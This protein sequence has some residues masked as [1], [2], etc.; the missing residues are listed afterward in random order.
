MKNSGHFGP[1]RL[2]QHIT[3]AR[4]S[5]IC[6]LCFSSD[7]LLAV[8]EVKASL[9]IY[10]PEMAWRSAFPRNCVVFTAI[11]AK[12]CWLESNY[13]QDQKLIYAYWNFDLLFYFPLVKRKGNLEIEL[14]IIWGHQLWTFYVALFLKKVKKFN[15]TKLSLMNCWP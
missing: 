12:L 1:L 9:C 13:R 6:N 4:D 11:S 10:L 8:I 15:K 14:T 2:T 3:N 7:E 5:E